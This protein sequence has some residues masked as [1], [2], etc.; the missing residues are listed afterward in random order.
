[1]LPLVLIMLSDTDR[2]IADITQMSQIAASLPLG[3][4]VGKD[5]NFCKYKKTSTPISL[6]MLMYIQFIIPTRQIY[7]L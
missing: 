2:S 3:L 5:A 6:Y 7:L 4:K 1:M